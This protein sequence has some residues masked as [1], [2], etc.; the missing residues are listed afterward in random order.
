MR[1]SRRT[2]SKTPLDFKFEEGAHKK[3]KLYRFLIVRTVYESK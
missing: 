1:N 2:H 3:G